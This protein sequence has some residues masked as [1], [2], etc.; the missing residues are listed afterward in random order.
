[1]RRICSADAV[2]SFDGE[3]LQYLDPLTTPTFLQI[4]LALQH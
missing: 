1:M 3:V 2:A 4:D